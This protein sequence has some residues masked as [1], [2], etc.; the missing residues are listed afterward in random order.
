MFDAQNGADSRDDPEELLTSIT[1]YKLWNSMHVEP[2]T[3]KLYRDLRGQLR[4]RE[5]PLEIGARDPRLLERRP[6]RL[7]EAV[8]AP[9]QDGIGELRV[10]ADLLRREGQK[11]LEAPPTSRPLQPLQSRQRSEAAATGS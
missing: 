5:R 1:E 9:L 11:L 4:H 8:R 2:V 3:T 6:H 10:V 7:L